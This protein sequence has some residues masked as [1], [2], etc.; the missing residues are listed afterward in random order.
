MTAPTTMP[1]DLP[2]VIS[3]FGAAAVMVGVIIGSG[4]FQTPPDIAR[5]LGSPWAVLGFWIAGGVLSLCGALT[6][7]ELA[8]MYPQSGGVYVFIREC[9]GRCAAF[10]FGWSY[11][12]LI[13]PLAAGG[14]A[15]VFTSHLASLLRFAL[16]HALPPEGQPLFPHDSEVITCTVLAL[17]TWINVRGVALG[18][19]VAEFLTTIKFVAVAALVFLPLAA[20][21]EIAHNFAPGPAPGSFI[22]AIAPVLAG[23]LWT[24]DGWADVGAIAGEVKEPQKNLP[25]IYLLGTLAVTAL[26]V[27]VN[28]AL[29]MAMPL[30]QMRSVDSVA[31]FAFGK[32]IGPS[33]GAAVAAIVVLSTLG[34]THSSIMTGARVTF[35]QARDGLL[36]SPLGK[37]SGRETPAVSLWVQL[38]LSCAAVLFFKYFNALAGGYVFTIFIFYGLA[39]AALMVFRYS[40]P[41]VPRPF[42]V[43]GYPLVPLAFIVVSAGMTVLT[44]LGDF[45]PDSKDRFASLRFLGIMALGVPAYFVWEWAKKRGSGRRT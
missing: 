25:R 44:I 10:V 37:V 3:P 31:P 1:K 24:F 14:I 45:A 8:C 7:A 35:Q 29:M 26:Y 21:G 13:K 34:S 2:R 38:V 42:R 23:V 18:T 22:Q 15:V 30:A 9:Y 5:H 43:P 11:M 36:F 41:G 6:F 40:R 12:L 28:A 32:L 39:A 16:P 33:A 19:R 27:A 20:P 4:I 17:L